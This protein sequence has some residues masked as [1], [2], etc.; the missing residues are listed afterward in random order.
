MSTAP[1][2]DARFEAL[3]DARARI[4]A[5]KQA[6]VLAVLASLESQGIPVSVAAVASAAGVSRSFVYGHEMRERVEEVKAR[7]GA[8]GTPTFPSRGHSPRATPE[9]LRADLAVAREEIRRLRASQTTLTER[10]RLQLG[11]EIEGPEKAALITRV[12]ELEAANRQLVAER[13]ARALETEASRRRITEL[14][15]DLNAA[16]ESLRRAIREHN[17]AR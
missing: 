11:A 5:G 2:V 16:R 14:E 9:S 6:R 8:L 15:D 3:R 13:D 10:L 17:R 12:A 4:S 1:A 7:Q